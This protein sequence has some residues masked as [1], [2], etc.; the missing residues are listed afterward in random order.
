MHSSR[1]EMKLEVVQVRRGEAIELAV[2][3]EIGCR[4]E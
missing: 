2:A 3:K 1:R 4:Q